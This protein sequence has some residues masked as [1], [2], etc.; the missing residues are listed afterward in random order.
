MI[1]A[2]DCIFLGSIAYQFTFVS[3]IKLD[4]EWLFAV[5]NVTVGELLTC[6]I[7]ILVKKFKQRKDLLCTALIFSVFRIAING[8]SV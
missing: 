2:S 8:S 4:L 6:N 1:T 7:A 3:R 5:S